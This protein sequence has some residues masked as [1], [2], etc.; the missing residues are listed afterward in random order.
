MRLRN[1]TGSDEMIAASKYVVQE[2]ATKK[3]NWKDFFGNTNPLHIEV[4]MGKG[5]F[6]YGMAKENPGI[7][8]IGIERYYTV[9]LRAIQKM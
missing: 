4:G 5:Q 8:Y 1:V 6:L 3:G 9:L 7:N 2:P